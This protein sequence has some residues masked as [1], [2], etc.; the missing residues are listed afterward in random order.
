M[1]Q[2]E[3]GLLGQRL[4]TGAAEIDRMRREIRQLTSMICGLIEGYFFSS[5][6]GL[7]KGHKIVGLPWGKMAWNIEVNDKGKPRVCAFVVYPIGDSNY[8]LPDSVPFDQI[9]LQDVEMVYANRWNLVR[10]AMFFFDFLPK[11]WKPLLDA[12]DKV[13]KQ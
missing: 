3:Y 7:Y 9:P 12:A 13:A 2:E 11:S 6:W 10:T 4:L 8:P 1:T 5:S